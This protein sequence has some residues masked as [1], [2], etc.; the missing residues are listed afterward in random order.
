MSRNQIR[1]TNHVGGTQLARFLVAAGL[2]TTL[3]VAFAL[4]RVANIRAAG[5]LKKLETARTRQEDVLKSARLQA[6]K[7]RSPRHLTERA[8]Q[9]NLGLVSVSHLEIYEAP[10]RKGWQSTD[11]AKEESR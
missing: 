3:V 2:A 5:E 8:N 11:L 6:E 7:L 9:M 10:I 1:R 4:L